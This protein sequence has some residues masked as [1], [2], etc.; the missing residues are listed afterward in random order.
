MSYREAIFTLPIPY[1]ILEEFEEEFSNV[2]SLNNFSIYNIASD[3]SKILV[4]AYKD[5]FKVDTTYTEFK[6]WFCGRRRQNDGNC[7]KID[8][9]LELK[10]PPIKIYYDL[11]KQFRPES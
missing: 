7:K 2:E 11:E 9:G 8:H 1:W 10:V 4:S 5:F 6:A 3:A